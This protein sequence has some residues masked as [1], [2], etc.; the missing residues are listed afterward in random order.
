MR[1][2]AR[3]SMRT[4]AKARKRA[5]KYIRE[6]DTVISKDDP[7]MRGRKEVETKRTDPILNQGPTKRGLHGHI[8]QP[9][10]G[11]TNEGR[12]RGDP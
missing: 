7:F 5:E 8:G 9:S 3:A 11:Q 1:S 2:L 4:L 12:K 6:E 10:Q